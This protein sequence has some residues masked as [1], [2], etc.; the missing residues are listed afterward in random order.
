MYC[1]N[2]NKQFRNDMFEAHA[3]RESKITSQLLYYAIGISG[4]HGFSFS[5]FFPSI[6][7]MV[8][9]SKTHKFVPLSGDW[10]KT[11]E[12]HFLQAR[13]EWFTES[14]MS[15]W[16][17]F[18]VRFEGCQAFKAPSKRGDF[19]QLLSL[20]VF[21]NTGNSGLTDEVDMTQIFAI[22]LHHRLNLVRVA[23]YFHYFVH[24]DRIKNCT[25]IQIR[26]I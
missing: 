8:A 22:S 16:L 23:K 5:G 24:F 14:K 18:S 6:P 3:A 25:V 26:E 17:F 10:A 12:K 20:I 7:E 4:F 21:C 2:P 19:Q 9:T 15:F 13:D 1:K 11:N